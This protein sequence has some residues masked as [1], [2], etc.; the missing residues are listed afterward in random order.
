MPNGSYACG[1][2]SIAGTGPGDD[3]VQDLDG[4]RIGLFVRPNLPPLVVSFRMSVP[5]RLS[6][7]TL[8]RMFAFGFAGM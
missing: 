8:P 5:I 4:A 7:P 6:H 2:F 3:R 1:G